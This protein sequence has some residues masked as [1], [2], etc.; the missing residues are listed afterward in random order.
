MASA[1]GSRAGRHRP[2]FRPGAPVIEAAASPEAVYAA[3]RAYLD[4]YAETGGNRR[5][6]KVAYHQALETRADVE[7]VAAA[8]SA[9][10]G[11]T[12]QADAAA[13]ASAQE[14]EAKVV[15]GLN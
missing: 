15:L 11:V 6:A 5:A 12:A 10:D 7:T 14:A 2:R 1:E 3:G 9:Y 13:Q 4:R 8:R